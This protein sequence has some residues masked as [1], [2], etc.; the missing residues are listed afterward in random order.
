MRDG[1]DLCD[2]RCNI[3][4]LAYPKMLHQYVGSTL[5][6]RHIKIRRIAGRLCVFVA[7]PAGRP[8]AYRYSYRPNR[9]STHRRGDLNSRKNAS[10]RVA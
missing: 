7:L 1:Q 10:R 8:N 4:L 9:S 3:T 6:C 5:R 2:F